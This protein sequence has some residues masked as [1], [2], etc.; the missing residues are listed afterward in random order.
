MRTEDSEK[1]DAKRLALKKKA[2]SQKIQEPPEAR[3]ARKRI[4]SGA[5]PDG[6]GPTN[7]LILS[8]KDSLG[9]PDFQN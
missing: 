1:K 6:N 4:L 3:K 9:A 2:T 5:S 8:P 7:V